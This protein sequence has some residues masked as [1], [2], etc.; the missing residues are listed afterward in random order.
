MS[1][2]A[3]SLLV[4]EKPDV[5]RDQV[6][7]INFFFPDSYIVVHVSLSSS[8]PLEDFV[9]AVK[10]MDNVVFNPNRIHTQWGDLLGPK[11]LNM[12]YAVNELA[13]VEYITFASSTDMFV[14]HGVRD[15]IRQHVAGFDHTAIVNAESNSH[16]VKTC[17]SD[18]LFKSLI[19]ELGINHAVYSQIEGSF[20]NREIAC[21][22]VRLIDK[23]FDVTT[24]NAPYYRE[25]FIFSTIAQKLLLTE[26]DGIAIPYTLKGLFAY[27]WA[28]S[29]GNHSK[30]LNFPSRLVAKILHN[31]THP[32]YWRLNLLK[33]SIAND[34]DNLSYFSNTK[35]CRK[36]DPKHIYAIKQVRRNIDDPVRNYL[37]TLRN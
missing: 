24:C 17:F 21:E 4:H 26:T 19:S 32:P 13:D 34:F 16:I 18:P 27:E 11:H 20:Y 33:K 9:S 25:E 23:H 15:Y 3:I 12:K 6:E 1:K 7:N 36:F 8:S 28:R 35:Y 2:T 31:T 37:R 14:R 5:F 22:I 29:F 30:W 10:D